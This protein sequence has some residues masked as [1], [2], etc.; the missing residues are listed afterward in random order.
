MSEKKASAKLKPGMYECTHTA[1]VRIGKKDVFHSST[2][3]TLQKK[4]LL[5]VGKCIENYV[6]KTM[7]Q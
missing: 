6:P 4:G 1:G 2:A 3:E 7:K 5:E